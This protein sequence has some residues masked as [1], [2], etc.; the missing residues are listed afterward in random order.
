M[1]TVSL[2]ILKQLIPDWEL[3]TLIGRDLWDFVSGNE[4]Y[5]DFVMQTLREAALDVLKDN[6][7]MDEINLCVEKVVQEFISEYGDGAEG[8]DN[9]IS[10]IF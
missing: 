3:R 10:N 4:G 5:V 2:G 8:V 9:Y 6:T 1:K 7:I